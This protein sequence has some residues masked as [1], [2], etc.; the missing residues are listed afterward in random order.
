MHFFT[1]LY[2]AAALLQTETGGD[3]NVFEVTG[4]VSG[5]LC[6]SVS[7]SKVRIVGA[8]A[9]ASENV[10]MDFQC[11][12]SSI[13]TGGALH[14]ENVRAESNSV[15]GYF[16]YTKGTTVTMKNVEIHGYSGCRTG[17]SFEDGTCIERGGGAMRI[18]SVLYDPAT[19]NA[20]SPT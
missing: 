11:I 8:T 15:D 14:L 1:Y 9:I 6:P 2:V 3:W 20:H 10:L 13:G 17:Q 5:A 16:L 19:N 12:H 7:G 18:R 4:T